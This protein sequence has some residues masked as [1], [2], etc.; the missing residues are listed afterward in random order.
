MHAASPL[1]SDFSSFV[2]SDHGISSG[3]AE[4][5]IQD[6]LSKYRPQARRPIRFLVAVEEGADPAPHTEE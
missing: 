3:E 6:W 5:L 4:R 2:A 1:A